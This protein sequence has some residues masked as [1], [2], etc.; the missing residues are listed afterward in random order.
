MS[1]KKNKLLNKQDCIIADS[2]GTAKIVLWENKI[3]LLKLGVS[4]KLMKL[5]LSSFRDLNNLT[6]QEDTMIEEIDDINVNVEDAELGLREEQNHMINGEIAV[7]LST[8][9]H[10]A[11]VNCKGEVQPSASP[12]SRAIGECIECKAKMKLAK[13][14]KIYNA[15]FVFEDDEGK[16]WYL[17]AFNEQIIDILNDIC[18]DG[19]DL[20]DELLAVPPMKLVVSSE[21]VVKEVVHNRHSTWCVHVFNL[22][23]ICV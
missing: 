18:M 4:Y 6:L 10:T 21:N 15:N 9:V 12:K 17:R 13:C 16:S 20:G 1:S 7:V 3:G 19:K 22:Y 5:A 14:L 23:L 2:T 11:C 8:K